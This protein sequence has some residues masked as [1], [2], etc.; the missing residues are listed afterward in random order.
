MP[1]NK[2]TKPNQSLVCLSHSILRAV[3]Y[4]AILNS[5][6]VEFWYKVKKI[7][8]FGGSYLIACLS[9]RSLLQWLLYRSIYVYFQLALGRV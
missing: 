7:Q 2:E 5:S 8:T 3:W 4:K 6:Y 1:L 9:V